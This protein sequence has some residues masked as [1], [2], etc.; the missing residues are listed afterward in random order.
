M[1]FF[2]KTQ[3]KVTFHN[4]PKLSNYEIQKEFNERRISLV[5]QIKDFLCNYDR[6]NNKVINV[7]FSEKGVGSLISII[8]TDTEKLIL[9]IPLSK[10]FSGSE[11]L[12][13]KTWEK[14]G[15]KVPKIIDKGILNEYSYILMEYIEAP[16]LSEKYSPE[17]M[18]KNGIGF[19]LCQI[20]RTMHKPIAN[21]Y[22]HTINGKAEFQ[23]FKD[24]INS[25][26]IQESIKYVQENKLLGDEHG[27][28]STA[29]K[30][31]EEHTNKNES[32]YCHN[33]FGSSNAFATDPITIFD[34]NP[35]FNNSYLDLSLS[36]FN[37]ISSGLSPQ[38]MIDEYFN[39]EQYNKNAL[40]SAILLNSYIKLPSRHKKGMFDQIKKLQEYL[41]QNRYL[42][43]D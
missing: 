11:G 32:S 31:L 25:S 1:F 15:V 34:P 10:K 33:D 2:K 21:G 24:W 20:L 42:L 9:K 13:L 36:L 14:A 18:G 22:G 4:Q 27:S 23:N 41:I 30:I 3:K 6:F 40:H 16:L 8:E 17:E 12:F 43:E 35:E 7:T 5:P 29:L 26:R 39:G 19:K 37:I 38:Q 28:L